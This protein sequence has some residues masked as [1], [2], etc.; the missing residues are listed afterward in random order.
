MAIF[1]FTTELEKPWVL[2]PL[3]GQK[4]TNNSIN[5]RITF[6][7][8]PGNMKPINTNWNTFDQMPKIE[9]SESHEKVKGISRIMSKFNT[10]NLEFNKNWVNGFPKKIFSP[11]KLIQQ[12]IDSIQN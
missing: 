2:L 11:P 12:S 7:A 9:G 5:D 4:G 6:F 8:E 10:K 1:P 3:L